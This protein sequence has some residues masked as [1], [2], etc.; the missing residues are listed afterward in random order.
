MEIVKAFNSNELHTDI[1]IKGTY[2][3]PLFRAS[4]IGVVLEISNIRTS[5]N[6]FNESEKVVHSMDTLGGSQQVTF[7]TE[8]GL[9]KVLFKSRKPIAEKFQNLVCEVIK[10]IRL[11]GSYILEK[12]LKEK[13]ELIQQKEEL[14]QKK[15]EIIQKK[16]EHLLL[17]ET[18]QDKMFKE[19]EKIKCP[20]IYIYNIDTRI[21]IPELKIGYTLNVYDRIRPYKQIC[22]HGKLELSFP[23][24]TNNIRTVENFIH[25]LLN[26]YQLKD[27]VFKLEVDEAKIIVNRIINMLKTIDISN[28]SERH[29]KLK[30]I[31]EKEEIILNNVSNLKVSTC[32]ISTQTNF[33]IE[34]KESSPLLFYDNELTQKF[35][36]YI[37]ELCIVREDVEVSSKE[38]LGQY[39]LWT[40]S[41]VKEVSIALKH[42]LDTRFKYGRLKLQ[43]KDQVVN[44]Y[45]GVMLKPIIYK[46]SLIQTDP[47]NFIFQVCK[48]NPAATILTS[49]LNTEYERWKK[50][51]GKEVLETDHKELKLYL[52]D[53]EHVLFETVWTTNSGS[54]QGFYGLSL[55]SDEHK[56]KKTSS[57]GK[58]VEKKEIQTNVV[59]GSWETIAKAAQYENISTSKMSI[60]IK[61]KVI[62]KDEYY[63]CT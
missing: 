49:T 36:K 24:Q 33:D 1:V 48:F 25:L 54:G 62:F 61:N 16:E 57:T 6:D 56:Y 2:N 12:Q 43:D 44:G 59:I 14:I 7:L 37:S 27:E 53:C 18:E 40:K 29:L 45:I 39:R 55:K 23:I 11:T 38:I 5:I 28:V 4:D 30:Q 15:E 8:K 19:T 21:N 41:A 60:S 3:E 63:Y 34:V 52:K 50:S 17:V 58:K 35:N 9:Y 32:E 10:E 46:K 20:S 31:Y 26:S 51:V 42:Y 22:K 47:E 13:E